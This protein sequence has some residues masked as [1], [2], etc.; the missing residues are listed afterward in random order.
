VCERRGG[1]FVVRGS[2]GWR[3]LGTW[4]KEKRYIYQC[5][6]RVEMA[7]AKGGGSEGGI[8]ITG[9]ETEDGVRMRI[10][11][12]GDG[13]VFLGLLTSICDRLGGTGRGGRGER[14]VREVREVNDRLVR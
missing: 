9:S 8:R 10:E 1:V 3:R 13:M 7:T 4:T 6:G 2:E 5:L 14:L 11:D 12:V